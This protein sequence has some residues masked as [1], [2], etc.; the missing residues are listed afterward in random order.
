[1]TG[2]GDK[3]AEKAAREAAWWKRWW[4]EDFSWEGL[5][6]RNEYGAPVKPWRGWSVT[7]SGKCVKTQS[8]SV[9]LWPASLQDYFRWDPDAKRLRTDQELERA[10][11]LICEETAQQP[12]FHILHLPPVYADGTPTFKSDLGAAEWADLEVHIARRLDR[13]GPT[14]KAIEDRDCTAVDHRA[15]LQGAV[16]RAFPRPSAPETRSSLHLAAQNAAFLAPADAHGVEFGSPANL[17]QAL[18]CSTASFSDAEFSGGDA[19]F[20]RAEFS[21]G[22]ANFNNARFSGGTAY[23]NRVRFSGG[24]TY[25]KRALFSGEDAYFNGAQF[26]GGNTYFMDAKFLGR[27]TSFYNAQ[28][29]GGNAYFHVAE[30]SG[31]DVS[32]YCTQFSGGIACFLSAEFSADTSFRRTSFLDACEFGRSDQSHVPP[33]PGAR[34]HGRLSLRGA[35]FKGLADFARVRFPEKAE[36]RNSAFEG[37]RFFEPLDLKGVERLP[38]SAFHGI[39][40]DKGLL[41]DSHHPEPEQFEEALSDADEAIARDIMGRRTRHYFERSGADARYAALEAGCRALKEAMAADGDRKR[42]Q[43]FFSHE[44]AARA[45]RLQHRLADLKREPKDSPARRKIAPARAELMASQLYKHLSGYGGSI[46][47]PLAALGVAGLTAGLV[48]VALVLG[49]SV[50]ENSPLAGMCIGTECGPTLHPVVIDTLDALVRGML[51]PFRL[52]A[53]PGQPFAYLGDSAPVFRSLVGTVMLLHGLVSSAL[54]F[55]WLLALR[56]QFQIN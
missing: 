55:L 13:S 21:G 14:D 49:F 29:S 15:Q 40:L 43:E 50:S 5:G 20:L 36:D 46:L 38:F 47:R 8:A 31:G 19:N 17:V 12:D 33:K 48:L 2:T 44:L 10:G 22:D 51:G 24:D 4:A 54:I 45:M 52:L 11:L 9:G 27:H 32:F 6:K 25:F 39:R 7:P 53:G 28:F 37:A 56:R 23:F 41:L 42:E 16:L 18:F 35:S 30:F 26:S 3:E 34:F 1:M